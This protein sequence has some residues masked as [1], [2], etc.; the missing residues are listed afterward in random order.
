MAS[1]TTLRGLYGIV[2]AALLAV[3]LVA[4]TASALA[5]TADPSDGAARSDTG[6]F[7]RE[8][9]HGRGLLFGTTWE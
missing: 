7:G 2:F 1:R 8:F 4:S 9:F 6:R 3:S 5:A